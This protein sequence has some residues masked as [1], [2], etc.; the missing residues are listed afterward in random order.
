VDT[1][2][3]LQALV[4]ADHIYVDSQTNKKVIAGTFN[5]IWAKEFPAQHHAPTWAFLCLTDVQRDCEITLRYVDLKDQMVLLEAAPLTLKSDDRLAS[6]ELVV[7]VPPFPMPHAG[8]YAFEVY[9][10]DELIGSLRISV[11]GKK[12]ETES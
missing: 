11:N 4:L 1:K 12:T 10:D 7:Q 8:V 9:A 6:D 5:R 2:P 3:V